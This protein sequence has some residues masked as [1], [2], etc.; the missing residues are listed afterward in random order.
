M[1][2][3][4]LLGVAQ[5]GSARGSGPRG[6]WFESSHSDQK[7]ASLLVTKKGQLLLKLPFFLSFFARN[8]FRLFALALSK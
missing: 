6:R 3:F 2:F 7:V 5:F 8:L 4:T 1:K